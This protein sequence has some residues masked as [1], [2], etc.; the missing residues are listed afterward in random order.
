MGSSFHTNRDGGYL[1]FRGTKF[2]MASYDIEMMSY[3]FDR[4]VLTSRQSMRE[5]EGQRYYYVV[6]K[7][8]DYDT[9]MKAGRFPVGREKY[10][11][12]N[13]ALNP[14]LPHSLQT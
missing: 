7:G 12:L 9:R 3:I 1:N 8:T 13:W 2:E 5:V 14:E 11:P 10:Y 6:V 4:A